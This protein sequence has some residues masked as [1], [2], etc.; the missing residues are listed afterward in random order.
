MKISPCINFFGNCKNAIEF[1][2]EIFEAYEI[3]VVTFYEKSDLFNL[4]LSHK[5]GEL[6]YRA[7]IYIRNNESTFSFVMG[8]SPALLF[9]TRL[10]DNPNNR[11]NI[12]F[13]IED[14][15]INWIEKIYY[16]L[17]ES[18]KRNT[19]LKKENDDSI[20]TGSVIDKYGICWILRCIS[21]E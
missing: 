11:D 20:I 18:G 1:Y 13:E 16:K 9:D 5:A 3:K 2:N 21:Q 12:T 6:I 10:N 4:N 19:P 15:D 8:D 7:E 14:N 17:L